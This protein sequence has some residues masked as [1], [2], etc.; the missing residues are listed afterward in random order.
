MATVYAAQDTLLRRRVAVKLLHT[1]VALESDARERFAREARAAARVSDHPNVVTIYDIGEADEL[2]FIVMEHFAGGTLSARLRNGPIERSAAL[3]WLSEAAAALDHAHRHGIVHRDVKPGNLLLDDRDRLAVGDFGIARMASDA[4]ELTQSGIVLGTAAYLSPE[5]VA[6]E[7]ATA[8]S[9][10]YSLAVVAFELLTGSKPY[11]GGH[12]AV[13]ALAHASGAPPAASELNPSL[14][15]EVDHVLWRGLD[16]RPDRRWASA[17]A[18][19]EAL[20][21]ATDETAPTR[22]AA[23]PPPPVPPRPAPPARGGGGTGDGGASRRRWIPVAVLVAFIACAGVAVALALGGGSGSDGDRIAAATTAHRQPA[24]SR[25]TSA[26]TTT[27]AKAKATTTKTTKTATATTPATTAT[28]APPAATPAPQTA[29]TPA[30]TA[31]SPAPSGSPSALEARGHQLIASGDAAAAIPVLQ[32]AVANCPVSQTDPC[33]YAYFD[34]GHALRLA[35]HPAEAIA[36]LQTRMQNAN[37]QG[38]VAAEL[39]A[40]QE[41]AGTGASDA[42]TATFHPGHGHGRG[43]GRG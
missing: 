7:P 32:A 14:P 35:G 12:A 1:H 42:P 9:D 20:E 40:A 27:K 8:A 22:R 37:Q 28:T 24:A 5:Q 30:Q 39:K 34:L 31:T 21:D 6:G 29:T 4:S 13:T 23:A 15:M 3:G 11:R 10:L 17:E 26:T 38:A 2:P 18:F 19:V 41:A 43:N 25:D 16:R 36:I 33:A